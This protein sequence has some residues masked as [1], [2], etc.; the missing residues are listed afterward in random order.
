MSPT[1][2]TPCRNH[3][4]KASRRSLWNIPKGILDPSLKLVHQWLATTC[5]QQPKKDYTLYIYISHI[6]FLK[7]SF[8]KNHGKIPWIWIPQTD[9]FVCKNTKPSTSRWL[10]VPGL[11]GLLRLGC[12][13]G[14]AG[15]ATNAASILLQPGKRKVAPGASL[16][17]LV[18][19]RNPTS[20]KCFK[21]K[22]EL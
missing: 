22:S 6:S 18:H 2:K 5:K 16:L 4:G 14:A 8:L 19:L 15:V 1:R 20:E 7:K 17:K 12:F 3:V 9:D 11:L 10:F 13:K 21:P